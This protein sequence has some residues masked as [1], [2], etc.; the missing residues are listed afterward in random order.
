MEAGL[1][2]GRHA[3]LVGE[4]EQLRRRATAA[5]TTARPAHARPVPRGQTGRSLGRLPAGAAPARRRARTRARPQAAGARAR[6]SEPRSVARHRSRPTPSGWT[7]WFVRGG[8][9]AAGIFV[10][11]ERELS[12]LED[13]LADARAGRGRLVV[14]AGE[15]G[16]GKSR[17]ADE[18]ASHAK[19]PRHACPLGPVLG[20]GRRARLLAV[21]AGS[22]NVRARMRTGRAARAAG[23]GSA[24]RRASPAGA[25]RAVRRRPRATVSRLGGSTLPTVR[26]HGRLHAPRCGGDTPPGRARRRARG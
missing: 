9:L 23:R 1:V 19:A 7:R 2:L 10:G 11:R 6:D 12:V 5:R 14:L 25:A 24:R 20:G 21:G 22:A 4:L 16:M 18:L 26:L 13:A 15:A 3:E 17:L 8:R